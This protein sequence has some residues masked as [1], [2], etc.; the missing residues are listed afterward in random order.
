MS[1]GADLELPGQPAVVGQ[2]GQHREDFRDITQAGRSIGEHRGGDRT[3]VTG[4]VAGPHDRRLGRG[5]RNRRRRRQAQE[6]AVKADKR[7]P[8]RDEPGAQRGGVVAM[9]ARYRPALQEGDAGGQRGHV[10]DDRRPASSSIAD[11]PTGP[12]KPMVS[13]FAQ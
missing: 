8:P 6:R 1:C 4:A 9:I 7:H 10:P 12:K 2:P 3:G 11:Q 5:Q 13:F